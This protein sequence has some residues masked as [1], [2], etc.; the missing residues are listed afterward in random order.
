DRDRDPWTGGRRGWPRCVCE[1]LDVR[2]DGRRP[3]RRY[4]ARAVARGADARGASV[5]TE[6]RSAEPCLLRAEGVELALHDLGL[7][8]AVAERFT[9]RS[10]KPLLHEA[11]EVPAR[12][13]DV[14]DD[15]MAVSVV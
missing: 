5:A 4:R 13:P 1:R 14:V 3:Q 15:E 12:L 9:D 8:R 10:L 2:R 6:F 11:V 7:A